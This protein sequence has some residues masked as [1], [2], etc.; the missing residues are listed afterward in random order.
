MHSTTVLSTEKLLDGWCG[1][2]EYL[3]QGKW[4]FGVWNQGS[5]LGVTDTIP[6][7]EIRLDLKR[8]EARHRLCDVQGNHLR[9]WLSSCEGGELDWR[10]GQYAPALLAYAVHNPLN[11]LS[12]VKFI[13]A[14]LA[15]IAKKPRATAFVTADG[16]LV[17]PE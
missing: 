6:P 13:E 10:F 4:I 9:Q 5:I 1:P 15:E 11:P 14:Y 16:Y 17:L 3:Y 12:G 8:P 7:T 2:V